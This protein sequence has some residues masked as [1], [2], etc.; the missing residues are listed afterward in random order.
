[1]NSDNTK[2]YPP[3]KMDL[4]CHTLRSDGNLEPHELIEYAISKDLQAIA[5]TDH[6]NMNG[7][8]EAKQ[9]IVNNNYSLKL[10]PG[11]EFSTTY[12]I[13]SCSY[14]IHVVGLF[15]DQKNISFQNLINKNKEIRNNRVIEISNALIKNNISKEQLD[16][17][18]QNIQSHNTF[19]TRKHLSDFL[20]NNGYVS[21]ND[22]AFKKYLGKKG[23]AYCKVVWDSIPTIIETIHSSNGIAI[24][25]HPIRYQEIASKQKYLDILI[26][27]FKNFGGDGMEVAHPNLDINSRIK[28]RDLAVKYD[29]FGSFGSDFHEISQ[30]NDKHNELGYNLYLLDKCKPI[31]EHEKMKS[32]LSL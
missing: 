9:T 1:M 8:E 7:I 29:L 15:C 4:H 18:I 14:Q 30:G 26:R 24:L 3:I 2:I 17:Y 27:D 25:A 19:I 6:D 5:I 13:G 16:L 31:W 20:V 12:F 28:L 21:D 32:Y 23:K 22:E 10:I 11:I